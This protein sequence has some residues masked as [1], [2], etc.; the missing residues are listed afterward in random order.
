MTDEVATLRRHAMAISSAGPTPSRQDLLERV[1]KLAPLLETAAAETE[2]LRKLPDALQAELVKAG[3]FRLL[4]PRAFGG[5]EVDPVTFVQVIEAVA[6]R[7]ASA[8]W[9]LCQGNGCAMV[10]A[11]LRPEIA[12]E[13]FAKD[14]A[15]ILAWGPGPGRAVEV[16]GGYRVTGNWAFASGGRHATWLG[17]HTPVHAPDGTPRLTAAGKPLVRTMLFP[18]TAAPFKD[19]W[20]VMG[21][22]GTGSDAYAVDDLFVPHDYALARDDQAER[23]DPGLLYCFPAGSL[24]A[25]GFGGVALGLARSLLDA[26]IAL[27][28]EKTARG[29]KHPL[30]H[31]AVIQA[32]IA[33]A[34]AQLGAARLYLMTSLEEIW[35]AVERTGEL[36]LAQRM[37]IRLQSTWA[38]HQAK[39]VGDVAYHAAGATAIFDSN[40]FERR[41]RD[42]H[43]VTQQL[44]GREAHYET[45]GQF[46]VGLDADTTWL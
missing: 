40:P 43:T 44:Q 39:E 2:H 1:E 31:N 18:A 24:Y 21:L 20:Q 45:V 37:Q 15:A 27:A 25:S 3:L 34:E 42:L 41:F 11:Y 10:A 23:R 32:K 46:L 26:F 29:F 9:C 12:L 5:A 14:P 16:D 13:I 30:A 36:T 35:R 8:A 22:R 33:K 17:A 38:I 4:L 28:C 7:D 6:K 19:I